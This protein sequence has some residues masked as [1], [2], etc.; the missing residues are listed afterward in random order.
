MR[1]HKI[2]SLM[3]ILSNQWQPFVDEVIA[4]HLL[5]DGIIVCEECHT[6]IDPQY[7]MRKRN[8]IFIETP[9]FKGLPKTYKAFK[10]SDPRFV[11][12]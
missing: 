10:E 7:R 4:L 11:P 2:K 9:L 8:A 5:S 3:Q 12:A 6:K 1:Q